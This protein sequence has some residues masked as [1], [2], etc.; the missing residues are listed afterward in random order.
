ML[1][2]HMGAQAF[3]RARRIAREQDWELRIVERS[4]I[5]FFIHRLFRRKSFVAGGFCAMIIWYALS[6]HVWF[7]GVE[8]V[9]RVEAEEVLALAGDA[10]LAPGALRSRLDRELVQRMLLIGMDDLVWA[11]VE[12]RGT[13]ALI[14]VAERRLIDTQMGRPGHI[15]AARDGIIERISVIEG[16][17]V[18]EPGM[19][20][21]KGEVLITGLLE[22]GSQA[23]LDKLEAEELPYI[24]ADGL[25]LARVWYETIVEV[26]PEATE[27]REQARHRAESLAMIQVKAQ[28]ETATATQVGEPLFETIW[29][30]GLEL[31]WVR[32]LLEGEADIGQFLPAE[33]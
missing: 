23:F 18:V 22:P 19:T 29:D 17:A 33:P 25:V 2:T 21:R 27:S 28:L 12:V 13:R 7:I 24:R 16:H 32:V 26:K 5:A 8:G 3:R 1:I 4:G 6:L 20:V 11:G 15:V 9:D 30:E 31:W 10:G 14:R